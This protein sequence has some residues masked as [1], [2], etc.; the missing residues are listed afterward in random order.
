M[1]LELNEYLYL[2]FSITIEWNKICIIYRYKVM[3]FF[4]RWWEKIKKKFFFQEY[5]FKKKIEHVPHN[6][7]YNTNFL[8]FLR[9]TWTDLIKG[10]YQLNPFRQSISRHDV[11]LTIRRHLFSHVTAY[12]S[13]HFNIYNMRC[14]NKKQWITYTSNFYFFQSHK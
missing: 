9:V 2:Q 7:L 5:I 10:L 6:V 14:K 3:V 8:R 13:V 11:L 4:L 1:L 12:D